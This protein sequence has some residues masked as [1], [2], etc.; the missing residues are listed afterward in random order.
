MLVH[1]CHRLPQHQVDNDGLSVLPHRRH[2]LALHN[3]N[4]DLTTKRRLIIPKALSENACMQHQRER[5]EGIWSR[6]TQ[7]YS[8]SMCLVLPEL[9]SYGTDGAAR[10]HVFTLKILPKIA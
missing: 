8:N 2:I 5:S 4:S 6:S 9:T 1:E 3:I 10:M 7:Q